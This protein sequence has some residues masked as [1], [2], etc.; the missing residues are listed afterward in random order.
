MLI[1]ESYEKMQNILAYVKKSSTFAP[2]KVFFE[3]I[4]KQ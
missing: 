4:N 3:L 2:K 1:H